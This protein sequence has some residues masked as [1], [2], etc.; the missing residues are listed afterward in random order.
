[1]RS[2]PGRRGTGWT[3]TPERQRRPRHCGPVADWPCSGT[4]S[5][6]PDVAEAFSAVYRHVMPDVPF[7]PWTKP[8]MDTYFA[9]F[10]KADDGFRNV[11][12]FGDLE[13]WRFDWKR[14]YTREE[15]LD[16]VPTHGG[17]SQ[18]PQG[19]LEG[20]VAGVGAAMDRGR[21]FHDGLCGGGDHRRT[22]L[23][24]YIC[25]TYPRPPGR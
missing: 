8:P 17:H 22:S 9:I 16:Q 18:L 20:T 15:W 12:A 11:G 6:P 23:S 24:A 1:M 19:Q 21:Q 10:T 4:C 3:P 13:Q 25:S 2:S 7:N 5:P 14:S